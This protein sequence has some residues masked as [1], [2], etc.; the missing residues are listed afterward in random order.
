MWIDEAGVVGFITDD[1]VLQQS[2]AIFSL[3]DTL[4]IT[5]PNIVF[6]AN[7]VPILLQKIMLHGSVIIIENAFGR[8]TNYVKTLIK[9]FLIML[10]ANLKCVPN[11]AIVFVTKP[12]KF[13]KP[14]TNII[15]LLKNICTAET[16]ILPEKSIVVGSNAG[17]YASYRL[18]A[19]RYDYDRALAHN[20]QMPFRTP[21]QF[22]LQS[23]IKRV[24]G[25]KNPDISC[26]SD[27]DEIE[28]SFDIIGK[29]PCILFVTGSKSSGKSMLANRIA[30]YLDNTLLLDINRVNIGEICTHIS[31]WNMT[32]TLII[33]DSLYDPV[34]E[35]YLNALSE[36]KNKIKIVEM[37]TCAKLCIFLD[38]FRLQ[39]CKSEDILM[40][41]KED[42]YKWFT[43][44]KKKLAQFNT[45]KFPLLLRKR[46]EIFYHY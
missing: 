32:Q 26:F 29:D 35:K 24:W 33:V 20:L 25:W 41:K 40:A 15:K 46:P 17:R 23:D 7:L 27:K 30:A 8:D 19:D 6:F 9:D 1:F 21:E 39:I 44:E 11:L 22:F 13:R 36:S 37:T 45:I 10:E 28:P 3:F 43:S 42:I 2:I 12:N 4:I 18:K 31:E 38:M 5:K 16:E 14:N 34:F